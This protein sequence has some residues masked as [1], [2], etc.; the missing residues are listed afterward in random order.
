MKTEERL[1]ADYAGTGLTTGPHPM[2][3]RRNEL[4][5]MGIL[6]AKELQQKPEWPLCL[7][8]G[9]GDCAAEAGYGNGVYL[10]VDG[11]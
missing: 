2:A 9:G 10:P 5:G 1:I 4:R 7:C 3:Y 11:G 6:S 8:G